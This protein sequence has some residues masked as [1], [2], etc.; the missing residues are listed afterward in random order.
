MSIETWKA[1][2][3]PVPADK[4]KKKDALA[5]SLKKWLGLREKA[6]KKHDLTRVSYSI[7]EAH[8]RNARLEIDS[9]SCALCKYY[10][11]GMFSPCRRCPLRKLRGKRCDAGRA[12]CGERIHS[13]WHSWQYESNPEP[14]IRLIRKAIKAEKKP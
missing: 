3:Y 2:F 6:L 11:L 9:D 12:D 10:C 8:F 1:E 5:H 14:M 7:S 4:C 13:P